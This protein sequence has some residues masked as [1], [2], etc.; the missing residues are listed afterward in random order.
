VLINIYRHGKEE[1]PATRNE[2]MVRV[3]HLSKF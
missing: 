2:M 3:R 1:A